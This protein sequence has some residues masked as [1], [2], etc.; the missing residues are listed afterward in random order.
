MNLHY[1][2]GSNSLFQRNLIHKFLYSAGGGSRISTPQ[3]EY[4]LL[5]TRVMGAVPITFPQEHLLFVMVIP[6]VAV[7][8]H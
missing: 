8:F 6:F 2:L 7:S 1:I 4:N 3:R 5:T